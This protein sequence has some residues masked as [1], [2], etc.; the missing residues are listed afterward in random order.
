MSER[1]EHRCRGCGYFLF[2]ASPE[3]SGTIRTVCRRCRR[4]QTIRLGTASP[5]R[6]LTTM[7]A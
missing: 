1:V 5:R 4:V 3:A 2:E 6:A 7:A